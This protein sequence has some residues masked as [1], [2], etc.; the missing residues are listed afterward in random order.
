MG[1]NDIGLL[2]WTSSKYR[3]DKTGEYDISYFENYI[4]ENVEILTQL[5]TSVE[6]YIEK[7]K[8]EKLKRYMSIQTH[9]LL[10]RL[11]KKQKEYNVQETCRKEEQGV[12]YFSS[13]PYAIDI[14][15]NFAKNS[16]S[17]FL[18]I[19][20]M[21]L[22]HKKWL[23]NYY[24]EEGYE[25]S[26]ILDRIL[27]DVKR[28]AQLLG[29]YSINNEELEELIKYDPSTLEELITG[30]RLETKIEKDENTKEDIEFNSLPYFV[31]CPHFTALDGESKIILCINDKIE[32]AYKQSYI[33]SL[34]EE[35]KLKF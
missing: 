10:H 14:Q 31:K 4:K 7:I 13:H 29:I 26:K 11:Y 9:N 18:L 12:G 3:L 22:V 2:S 32:I 25:D 34:D 17:Y 1:I 28:A 5:I 23:K 16:N 20:Y 30:T 21:N 35:T 27:H 24:S 8:D 19:T 15:H 6:S 33:D